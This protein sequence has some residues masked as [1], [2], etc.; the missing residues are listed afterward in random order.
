[1]YFC[2][3]AFAKQQLALLTGLYIKT[4]IRNIKKKGEKNYP[5]S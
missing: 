5:E 3:A 1:M 4:L 2:P